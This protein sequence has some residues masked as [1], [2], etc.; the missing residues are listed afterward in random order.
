MKA[1]PEA[2]ASAG[3]VAEGGWKLGGGGGGG[4]GGGGGH[5]HGGGSGGNSMAGTGD[6]SN[7][8]PRIR[9]SNLPAVRLHL[10]LTNH[11]AA[12]VEVE[13]V[14][15]ESD[16]GN[17]VVEPPKIQLPPGKPVEA[18]PMTSRLGVS[19]DSVPLTVSLQVDGRK[20]TQVLALQAVIP[21][22]PPAPTP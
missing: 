2:A 7:P 18:E 4:F 20:E 21:A 1:H 3:A 6:D 5:R 13:V 16:L 19:S 15:F 10:R 17:F 8:A 11:G 12:A 22:A 14:D 9:P